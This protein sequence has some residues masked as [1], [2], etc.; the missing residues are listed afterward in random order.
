[1]ALPSCPRSC[2][3]TITRSRARADIF[4]DLAGYSGSRPR[5]ELTSEGCPST[6]VRGA[7]LADAVGRRAGPSC[8]V[9]RRR[10]TACLPKTDGLA[11]KGEGGALLGGVVLAQQGG[12]R[13]ERAGMLGPPGL[14]ERQRVAGAEYLV[15][16]RLGEHAAGA[17]PPHLTAHRIQHDEVMRLA[18]REA[19]LYPLAG[20]VRDVKGELH[21]L[22]NLHVERR[23]DGVASD[24]ATYRRIRMRRRWR[25]IGEREGRSYQE[26]Q[27]VPKTHEQMVWDSGAA[28]SPSRICRVRTYQQR[29]AWS[30]QS[31]TVKS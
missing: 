12:D 4:V 3:L 19:K 17:P 27:D 13:G 26:R 22:P 9:R 29:D 21:G 11:G 2:C 10:G 30:R 6:R 25:H 31:V 23:R 1:M 14:R 18:A 20:A 7:Q 8:G 16:H 15:L 28:S 24:V 5:D